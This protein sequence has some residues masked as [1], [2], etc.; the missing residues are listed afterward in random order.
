M[1]GR[2]LIVVLFIIEG[3]NL[4]AQGSLDFSKVRL[5]YSI[6]IA[7]DASKTEMD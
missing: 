4:L 1:K 7:R 6:R 5:H 3:F 2:L